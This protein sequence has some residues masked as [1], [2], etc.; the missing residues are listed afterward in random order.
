MSAPGRIVPQ[1]DVSIVNRLFGPDPEDVTRPFCALSPTVTCSTMAVAY[2]ARRNPEAS[3]A[4][5][6]R[7]LA[8]AWEAYASADGK[9]PS[10]VKVCD[11]EVRLSKLDA[12]GTIWTNESAVTRE[13]FDR[14]RAREVRQDRRRP[15]G[16]ARNDRPQR[17]RRPALAEGKGKMAEERVSQETV[18]Q[19]ESWPRLRFPNAFVKPYEMTDQNGR[20]WH[21]AICTIP[22]GVHVNGVDVGGFSVDMFM[23]DFHMDMKTLGKPVIFR[24]D[25]DKALKAFKGR[26]EAQETVKLMP[27]DLTKALAKE[28]REYEAS[29]AA[30]REGNPSLEAQAHEA[31]KAAEAQGERP[32]SRDREE[33]V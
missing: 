29:K 21:K 23:R 25:P 5:I 24:L 8:S 32:V 33:R 2:V 18:D 11:V 27:W 9:G 1:P 26:G 30:E 4:K 13:D 7:E 19:R 20:P 10:L 17:G 3:A 15:R 12:N 16:R 22:A 14:A 31:Q 28:R 6:A